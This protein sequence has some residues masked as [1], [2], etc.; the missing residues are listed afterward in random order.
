M[1]SGKHVGTVL[2]A[3]LLAPLAAAGQAARNVGAGRADRRA[4][5]RHGRALPAAIVVRAV[6]VGHDR[7]ARRAQ[8]HRRRAARSAHRRRRRS[9]S[10]PIA[11]TASR[12][13]R[14]PCRSTSGIYYCLSNPPSS[15]PSTPA[16]TRSS[17]TPGTS[18]R[19]RRPP[20][21]A[22]AAYPSGAGPTP[23]P[24]ATLD[25]DDEIVF[26]A[27]DAGPQA[28]LGVAA[29]ARHERRPGRR[30]SSIRS[31]P[32]QLKFV[33]LF[34]KAGGSSFTRR[35]RLRL[36][37]ARRQRRRMDRSLQHRARRSRNS[38]RQQHR[39]RPEPRRA[40]VCRTAT[41]SRLSGGPD[42]TPR[43]STDRFV[44]DGVTVSTDTLPV[45]RERALDGARAAH[46]QAGAA[47][48]LR[49]RPHRP[50]EGAR[51][52]AEPRLDDL[53]GRLRGRAGE[54]GGEQRARSASAPARC[55]RSARSGAPTRA[56]T[57]PR[58]RPSIA[59]RSTYRYHVRVHPIPPDGLYT[60]WDYNHGVVSTLLQHHQARRRAR[61]TGMNDDVGN[62]DG[63]FGIPAF[64]DA[65]DPTFNAPSAILN[66][67]ADRRRQRLRLARLHRRAEG[68][69]DGASTRRSCRTTATTRASTTAPAT[70][71]CAR[72][73]P[74]EASTDQRVHDGYVAANGGTPYAQLTCEQKQGAWGAH[75]IHYFFSGDSDNAASPEVLTEIDAQQWQFMVPTRRAGERRAA[76]RAT[77]HR[78]AAEGRRCRS[79]GLPPLLPPSASDGS[80]WSPTRTSP[81]DATL[82]GHRS[83]HAAS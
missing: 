18:S 1:H 52:P 61:S 47:R 19:G 82:S 63:V 8:R 27:S 5:F 79:A 54:L 43:A 6:S 69:D 22:R 60:S 83:R 36:L 70:I 55:A 32:A 64:F 68:R 74:G 66:W 65:P 41:L 12:S 81:V 46:R 53:A 77:R 57:S 75:G 50:L 78:A 45:A 2:A 3:A 80:P 7:R 62:V 35:Q 76:V 49:P 67:E 38:R 24:V 31:I 30:R 44:R 20:G 17:P 51:L 39:L 42:G 26:M 9:R 71:P 58:P 73:W 56:P 14:S 48:R 13:R 28:P 34:R 10:S 40:R 23:D 37:C 11:G 72:P 21:N 4:T 29:T 16:P 33:Y 59:T 25:D 15:S